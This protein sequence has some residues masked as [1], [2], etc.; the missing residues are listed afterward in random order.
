M[1]CDTNGNYLHRKI[2]DSS[3]HNRR[4]SI[5]NVLTIGDRSCL[6]LHKSDH[7]WTTSEKKIIKMKKSEEMDSMSLRC[8]SCRCELS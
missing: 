5:Y 6:Q 1:M 7:E 2:V 4:V 3:R 8:A